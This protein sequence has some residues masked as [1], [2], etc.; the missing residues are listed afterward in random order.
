MLQ[1]YL[2][3]RP[4]GFRGLDV[5]LAVDLADACEDAP[6]HHGNGVLVFVLVGV[7]LAP[8]VSVAEVGEGVAVGV[9]ESEVDDV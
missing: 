7:N 6:S 4:C 3:L 5:V 8:I 2:Y 9:I 1:P